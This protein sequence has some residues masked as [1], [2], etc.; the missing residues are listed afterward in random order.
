M[1]KNSKKINFNKNPDKKANYALR[2]TTLGLASIIVGLTLV[3]TNVQII[4]AAEES[5]N[6]TENI[7]IEEDVD[8]VVSPEDGVEMTT[9][10]AKLDD[11]SEEKTETTPKFKTTALE[12]K[13]EKQIV[14]EEKA[15]IFEE[16]KLKEN[17]SADYINKNIIWLDYNGKDTIIQDKDNQPVEISTRI[18]NNVE[19]PI[20]VLKEGLKITQSISDQYEIRLRVK[21]V[22]PFTATDEFKRR[23]T[24]L[25]IDYETAYTAEEKIILEKNSLLWN[26]GLN[27]EEN[28]VIL[29]NV[30]TPWSNVSQSDVEIANSVIGSSGE[31]ANIGVEFD[32]GLYLKGAADTER[33]PLDLVAI[34]AEEANYSEA[35]IMHTDGTSWKKLSELQHPKYPGLPKEAVKK[36][37]RPF[38]STPIDSREYDV[39]RQDEGSAA[40]NYTNLEGKESYVGSEPVSFI[41]LYMLYINK[42]A[43]KT[44]TV[45]EA[46]DLIE[47]TKGMYAPINTIKTEL[48]LAD[49]DLKKIYTFA[50]DDLIANGSSEWKM[51]NNSIH[52][53]YFDTYKDRFEDSSLKPARRPKVGTPAEAWIARDKDFEPS[54]DG[55]LGTQ[56]F[57]PVLTAQ[58]YRTVPIVYTSNPTEVGIYINSTGAQQA[59][60]GFYVNGAFRDQH[61]YKTIVKN[62][63]G[64]ENTIKTDGV[65]K[66]KLQQGRPDMSY[67]TSQ[68]P[69]FNG[70][71]Y[72]NTLAEAKDEGTAVATSTASSKGQFK[73]NE[74]LE[75][76]YVYQRE[77]QP[78]RFEDTHRYY[79]EYVNEKGEL[80]KTEEFTELKHTN[81]FQ[82][83]F[84][85]DDKGFKAS[86]EEQND[87]IYRDITDTKGLEDASYFNKKKAITNG[88]YVPGIL[89]A[90]EY[91]YFK[92]VLF[93]GTFKENHE[94]YDIEKNFEGK[95]IKREKN[96]LISKSSEVIKGKPS[97]KYS[98][99]KKEEEGYTFIK[100]QDEKDEPV[101]D[102]EKGTPQEGNFEIGKNKEITY[103]YEK[104][105]QPGR[106]EDTH[107]YFIE[108]Y[109]MENNLIERKEVPSLKKTNEFQ[110]G[111]ATE[112]FEAKQDEKEGFTFDK[113]V[114]TDNLKDKTFFNK[115]SKITQ[116]KFVPG[117]KQLI[118]Y[119]Y[120]KKEVI[121]GKFQEHHIYITHNENGKE[122]SRQVEE[123]NTTE[124]TENETYTTGKKDKLGYTFFTTENPVNN[125]V[126]DKDGKEVPGKY[127]PGMKQEITY[128]YKRT[129]KTETPKTET[130]KTE[131]PKTE[132]PKTE[133]PKTETPKTETPK[134]ETP[135][136]ETPTKQMQEELPQTGAVSSL[137]AAFIAVLS[138]LGFAIP[139]FKKEEKE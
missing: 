126:F 115:E 26:H 62:F 103:V 24:N 3:S 106:F 92:K 22:Q 20:L 68:I 17:A 93:A 84:S 110:E 37:K 79:I 60:I 33:L 111:F 35:I 66:G 135:K 39:H 55:G 75:A 10:E 76:K 16:F 19:E 63:D 30:D 57:G 99:S 13:T 5:V 130:P 25:G 107:R 64:T 48:N 131:T 86:K 9:V 59:A 54:S 85:D 51:I 46:R 102:K 119:E 123:G 77:I 34:D 134:T 11:T 118:D 61:V 40:L 58:D 83:G 41:E 28:N 18:V 7:L 129:V 45:Q 27:T 38:I 15:K 133:T 6:N 94:Y 138:G 128:V 36:E 29:R 136:T 42:S 32:I 91:N 44:F 90:V 74:L 87:F 100:T 53:V 139:G 88:Q 112:T 8:I 81:K 2:K 70:V 127:V 71:E 12:E 120:V 113:I 65:I 116:G 72:K 43:D 4:Q 31:A 50:K 73:V 23:L 47:K 69:V 121:V 78:G 108:Y 56:W 132:T 104:V 124:G 105:V 114:S 49:E 21:K 80:V 89:Q 98:T 96:E 1:I 125:P 122:I 101:Y 52:R 97:E 137:G 82:E 67:N 117:I 109:D 14:E 95:E